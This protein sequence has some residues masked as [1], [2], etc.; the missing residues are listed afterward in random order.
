MATCAMR[1]K[2][3]CLL[4]QVESHGQTLACGPGVSD[5]VECLS[6]PN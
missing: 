4:D 3:V 1:Y 5:F 2:D 6:C